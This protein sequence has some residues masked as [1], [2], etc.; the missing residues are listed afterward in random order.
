MQCYSQNGVNW[1]IAAVQPHAF[2]E[3]TSSKTRYY[4]GVF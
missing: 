2:E 1:G 4:V 3:A